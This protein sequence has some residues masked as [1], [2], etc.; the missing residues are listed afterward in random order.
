MTIDLE[1]QTI[2]RILTMYDDLFMIIFYDNNDVWQDIASMPEIAPPKPH[3][4][5]PLAM[6]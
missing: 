6:S 3:T 1:S 2:L 5:P 4:D